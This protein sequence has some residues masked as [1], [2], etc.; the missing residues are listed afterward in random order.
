[1]PSSTPEGPPISNV[2]NPPGRGGGG[3][4]SGGSSTCSREN[5]GW[6][7]VVEHEE[8]GNE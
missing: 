1:M 6:L 2:D 4:G 8:L 7:L 5:D 3:G